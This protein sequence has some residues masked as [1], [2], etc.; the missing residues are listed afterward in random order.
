VEGGDLGFL[1][2]AAAAAAAVDQYQQPLQQQQ[3][4]RGGGGTG[5]GDAPAQG[6]DV[7]RRAAVAAALR[8]ATAMVNAVLG[9]SDLSQARQVV[10][11]GGS[12][13]LSALG[14]LL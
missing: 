2:D 11:A 12:A 10:A 8:D 14:S 13:L 3:Q 4:R 1:A 9:A 6:D 5:A 7:V